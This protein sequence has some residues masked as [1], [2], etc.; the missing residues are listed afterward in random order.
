MPSSSFGTCTRAAVFAL[1]T[2]PAW[3]CATA[4]DADVESASLAAGGDDGEAGAA[5]SGNASAG[6]ASSATAGTASAGKGGASTGASGAPGTGGSANGGS[7]NGGAANGG[8]SGS[9]TGKGGTS[10]AGG[11]GGAG[12]GGMSGTGSAGKGGTSGGAS[13]SSGGGSAGKGGSGSASGGATNA[14]GSSGSATCDAAHAVATITTGMVYT[15]KANDCV[16]LAVNPTW[17]TIALQF[18]PMPGTAAYPVPFSFFSCG[19][20]GTGALTAD[21]AGVIFKS[22]ANPGCDFFVQFTGGGTTVKVTYYD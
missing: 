12:K 17:S 10:S 7:A 8:G 13:G 18:Q 22:G 21:Y 9:H 6:R 11:T 16:R 2:L 5:G 3:A 1:V 20:N 15:G 14:G 19:G 4:I